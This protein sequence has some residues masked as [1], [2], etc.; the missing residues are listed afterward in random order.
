[1]KKLK[2]LTHLVAI[3]GVILVFGNN[4]GWFQEQDRINLYGALIKEPYELE[5]NY[6]GVK[7]FLNEFYNPSKA[8]AELKQVSIK[9]IKSTWMTVGN[10]KPMSGNVHLWLEDG[11]RSTA[12]ATFDELN[13][14]ARETPFY[15]WASFIFL[16]V[17]VL[18]GIVID[19]VP[20]LRKTNTQ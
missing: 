3:V 11:R 12:L 10:N 2:I 18:G 16:I 6:P 13:D 8:N 15:E 19:V 4:L 9:G 1:M 17:G 14:W 20:R 5:I 7:D